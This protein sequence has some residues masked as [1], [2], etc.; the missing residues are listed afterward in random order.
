MNG[1]TG[2]GPSDD[3]PCEVRPASNNPETSAAARNR[4]KTTLASISDARS[5][6]DPEKEPGK[7]ATLTVE[8]GDAYS[9][10][11]FGNRSQNVELAIKYYNEALSVIDWK[12]SPKE[13]AICQEGLGGA[14]L[15][16]SDGCD[17]KMK[18]LSAQHFQLALGSITKESSPELWHV[19]HLKLYMLF[20]RYSTSSASDDSRPR[21]AHYQAA[22]DVDKLKQP[23]LFNYVDTIYNLHCR[24]VSLQ[25]ELIKLQAELSQASGSGEVG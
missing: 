3:N 25:A 18:E 6:V 11:I 17:Q 19:I 13:W 22:V 14:Y 12:T 8:L 9:R 23:E 10:K 4:K 24:S 2:E 7:W 20:Q 15:Q 21:D 16:L 1:M 5:S